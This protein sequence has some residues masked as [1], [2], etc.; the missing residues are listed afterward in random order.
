MRV[1]KFIDVN[2]PQFKHSKSHHIT[3]RVQ[4]NTT[5]TSLCPYQAVVCYLD[6]R[7]HSSCS[8]RLSSFMDGNPITRH[9]FTQQLQAPLSFCDLNLQNYHTHRIGAA[10]TATDKGFA[11]LYIQTTG[12]WNSNAFWKY[13]RIP[14]LQL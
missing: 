8:E 14:T 9:Y 2:I 6:L 11:E 3:F 10:S 13:I 1:R 7:K 5:N 4:K 12:R